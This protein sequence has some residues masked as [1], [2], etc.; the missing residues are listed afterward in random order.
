MLVKYF[1]PNKT[2]NQESVSK[3]KIFFLS[4]SLNSLKLYA[5]V[6]N[7][8]TD[9]RIDEYYKKE[10]NE[11]IEREDWK[12]RSKS[13]EMH[14]M[15]AETFEKLLDQNLLDL[16]EI[17]LLILDEVH[18]ILLTKNIADCYTMIIRKL[19]Q[20]HAEC[21]IPKSYRILGLSAS[22]L[23]ENVPSKVFEK[24]IEQIESE[25][26]CF[27]ETYADLRM[28]NKYSI[29]CRIK[30]RTYPPLNPS[31]E[32]RN[33]ATFKLAIFL[34]R[35]HAAQFFSFIENF[36]VGSMHEQIINKRSI[37]QILIDFLKVFGTMGEWC[38]LKLIQLVSKELFETIILISKT[39]S[40]YQRMLNTAL[41]TLQLL[42]Q[43]ILSYLDSDLRAALENDLKLSWQ[44][45]FSVSSPKLKLLVE[46]LVHYLNNSDS[47]SFTPHTINPSSI[48]SLIYAENSSS[49]RVL[50]EWLRELA[51]I[52]KNESNQ[53]K[54]LDYLMPDHVFLDTDDDDGNIERK[55]FNYR[56]HQRSLHE[57]YYHR[58]QE[59]TLKKFRMAHNCNVLVTNSMSAEGLDVNRCNLVICFDPPQTFHQFILSKGRVRVEKGQF[60]VL[61]E[62]NDQSQ[63]YVE[64]FNEFC[65]IEKI[66]TKLVPLNNQIDIQVDNNI[67]IFDTSLAQKQPKHL[68]SNLEKN[69]I[70][71]IEATD[72]KIKKEKNFSTLFSLTLDNAIL[73]LNRYC[74]KLPSDTF[75][76]L[77]PNYKIEV[78]NNPDESDSKP[79]YR[80][81]LFLP[82]NS[83]YRDEIIGE[84]MPNQSLAKQAAA[85]KAVKTLKEIGELDQNYYPIGKET[86]RYIEKLGLQECFVHSKISQHSLNKNSQPQHPKGNR[87]NRI[88]NRN[89]ASK[90]RQY[91]KKKVR[92]N[93]L[94][95]YF[96]FFL[97]NCKLML[98]TGF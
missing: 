9:L 64:K 18:K 59:E 19:K 42:K 85:F 51:K 38:A 30:L 80:C 94:V 58:R 15:L 25:L 12:I 75:T 37:S 34:I 69:L 71:P 92:L 60:Y 79:K 95:L 77:V 98:E 93:A 54:I 67:S 44:Q 17:N 48:C 6:F 81:H 22:I 20:K 68:Q 78:L 90:R 82:I 1:I 10:I 53:I 86:S 57:I 63:I 89:I 43:S 32:M 4:K 23:L 83:T 14:L 84:I 65:N 39:K 88:Q 49:V 26:D 66:F 97:T 96:A 47:D 24:M 55:N 46:I 16:N 5:A 76:K 7:A 40:N 41:S 70:S 21:L 61:L 72:S 52:D 33:N 35:N 8:H 73:F 56:K 74:N 3:Q 11:S 31:N 50:D 29:G 27:C 36:S 91:Y 62:R 28:I 13:Y 2:A 87:F 45:F